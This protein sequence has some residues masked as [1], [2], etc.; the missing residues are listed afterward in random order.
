L[1]VVGSIDYL[2][3]TFPDGVSVALVCDLLGLPAFVEMP[4]GGGGYLEQVRSANVS[5][6]FAG[7][8]GMGCHF[9]ASG[10]GCR[11]LEAV[12]GFPG[13]RPFLG[14]LQ[15]AG[16]TPTRCDF[17]FDDFF[18]WLD[19][20]TI[21]RHA[22]ER[23]YVARWET[24]DGIEGFQGARAGGRTVYFGSRASDHFLRIYDKAKEQLA[25][26]GRHWIRVEGVYRRASAAEIVRR[27]VDRGFPAVAEVI[28]GS[29]R[30]T[31]GDASRGER[32]TEV[33]WW[34]AFLGGC[35]R[36]M[37]NLAGPPQTIEGAKEW[38]IGQVAPVLAMIQEAMGVKAFG[39][40]AGEMMAGGRE[41]W[42]PKHLA[43]LAAYR[44]G[45]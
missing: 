26:D 40:W 24:V 30:F 21:I 44:A 35:D 4:K 38:V 29:L 20:D 31:E 43:I 32:S 42:T 7:R 18:G 22:R 8:P 6:L 23:Q 17:A 19:L 28:H 11:E 41:R 12:I 14:I 37:L 39:S 5:V 36:A 45:P 2:E 25:T 27:F 16:A 9:S 13:W 1:P 3:G 10:K 15:E 34:P 33:A